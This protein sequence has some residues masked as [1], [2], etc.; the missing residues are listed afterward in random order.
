TLF[1]NKTSLQKHSSSAVNYTDIKDHPV[2]NRVRSIEK[3]LSSFQ[4][5]EAAEFKPLVP[6]SGP[7]CLDSFSG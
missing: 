6:Y 5:V 3:Q 4:E 1:I 7:I 2:I